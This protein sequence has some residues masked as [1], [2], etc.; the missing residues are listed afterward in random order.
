MSDYVLDSNTVAGSISFSK[1]LDI[2]KDI[3][4]SFDYACYG[5]N[6]QG[7]EGFCVFFTDTFNPV[8]QGG[9]IGPGLA[10]S[11]VI[12]V[13]TTQISQQS[14]N[15][16]DLGGLRAGRLGVGFDITGNFGSSD[17]SSSGFSDKIQN[18]IALRSSYISDFNI[19]TR[20]PNL[21][22]QTFFKNI[23]LYQQI[24]DNE[25]PI[26][27]RVR[28]RL[29]DFGQRV[30]VDIK[31]I[32]DLNFTNYLNYNFT[33]YNNS[34]LSSTNVTINNIPLSGVPVRLPSTVQCGLGFST[35]EDSNTIFKIRNF[36]INGVFTTN[37]SQGTYTYD[38]DN[39]TLIASQNYYN[40]AAPYFFEGDVMLIQ[41]TKDG[42]L[43]HTF[44]DSTNPA[45]TGTPLIFTTANSNNNGAPYK[46]G[47]NFVGVTQHS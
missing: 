7:N 14:F 29:T 35:G 26:F 41:N 6:V 24:L 9:G 21:N 31:K 27:K 5:P 46:A 15:P 20:T 47:D 40:P 32:G 17:Y 28:V 18:S 23:N 16:Q 19:I 22:D 30:I 43:D 33:N 1:Y 36:N 12:N 8:I 42:V 25:D 44:T 11:S 13:D 38:V 37:I 45:V 10:Y 34:L 39:K 4:V 2:T 3:V